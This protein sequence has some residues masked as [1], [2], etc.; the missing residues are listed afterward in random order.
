MDIAIIKNALNIKY[1]LL[2][3]NAMKKIKTGIL[4]WISV[5]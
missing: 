4:F 3:G 5:F 2:C 1:F